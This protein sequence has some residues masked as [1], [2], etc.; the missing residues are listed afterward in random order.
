MSRSFLGVDD[1]GPELAGRALV[2]DPVRFTTYAASFALPTRY[3]VELRIG[4]DHRA[5]RRSSW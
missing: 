2:V 5:R 1:L 3:R 4:E